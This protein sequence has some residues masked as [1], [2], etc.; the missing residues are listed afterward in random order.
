MSD[1]EVPEKAAIVAASLLKKNARAYYKQNR[2]NSADHLNAY[3]RQL[4]EDADI[5]WSE[6]DGVELRE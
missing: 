2:T 6:L 5:E 1:I 4:C 3:A